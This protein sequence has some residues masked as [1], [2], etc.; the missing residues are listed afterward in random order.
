MKVMNIV[1]RTTCDNEFELLP[2]EVELPDWISCNDYSDIDR[3]LEDTED[4]KVLGY[5]VMP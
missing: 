4:A 1:W 5:T 2:S 3:Y